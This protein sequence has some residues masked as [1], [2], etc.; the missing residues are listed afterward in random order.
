MLEWWNNAGALEQVYYWVALPA[1]G[2]LVVLLILNFIGG[3]ADGDADFDGD[4]G[5]Q[6]LTL[7]NMV[8]F[9]SVFG[10]TG[11]LCIDSGLGNGVTL[12]ISIAAGVAMM[13]F[14][15]TMFLMLNRATESGTLVV[16]NAI[17]NIGETYLPIP[18]RRTGYGKVQIRVQGGLRE[19]EAVT[20]D[21]ELIPT[22]KLVTVESIVSGETLVV[23]ANK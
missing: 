2:I 18:P 23:K 11:L 3:D 15:A 10:W 5:F 4:I 13:F 21:D 9:F 17:G 20:D 22:G 12:L 16:E 7:K 6:F 8:G 14:L 19:L 1:T